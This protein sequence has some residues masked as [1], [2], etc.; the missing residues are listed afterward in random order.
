MKLPIAMLI[1]I[2][3]TMTCSAQSIFL[4]NIHN[5]AWKSDPTYTDSTIRASDEIS[6]RQLDSPKEALKVNVT[7]WYF[8]DGILTIKYYDHT[9]R[10]ETSVA[11]YSYETDVE[12]GLLYIIF[13]KN[14]LYYKVGVSST[15]SFV[16]LTKDVK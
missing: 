8:N 15:G 6:L 2:A 13:N 4:N 3:A 10:K 16:L 12:K 1:L 5:S 14:I 9:L 7:L 11:A